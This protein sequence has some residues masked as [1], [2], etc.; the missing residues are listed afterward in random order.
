[1]ATKA[2]VWVDHKQAIVV[3]ITDAGQEIK[4]IAFDI[5]R[6]ARPTDGSR[7]KNKYTPNDFVAEDRRER[8]VENDRKNYYDDVIA[9][10]RGAD[11]LVIFGPG[12]AKGELH[13][14]ITA[15]KLRGLKV[16]L[17]TTDKMTER[18]LVAK[19]NDHFST[20]FASKS[21]APK[22]RAGANATSA[23]RKKKSGT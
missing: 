14:H 17:E 15:K 22:K 11:A 13:K 8:K 4:K 21:T 9:S 6:P 12:E 20:T 18:Q 2:G 10:F 16:E 19:V 7:P 1:M 23:T 5:G 3:L